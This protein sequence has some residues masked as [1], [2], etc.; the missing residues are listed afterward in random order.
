MLKYEYWSGVPGAATGWPTGN[1]KKQ[2]SSQTQLDQV[3]CLAVALFLA[4]AFPVGHPVAAPGT[5]A[6]Y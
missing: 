2:S 3:T 6:A 4:A 5:A 1:G